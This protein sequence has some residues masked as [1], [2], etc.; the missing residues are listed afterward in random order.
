MV[1][2]GLEN[3]VVLVTGGSR[4]IGLE[5]ARDLLAQKAKVVICARKQEGLEKAEAEL[6]GG[7]NLLTVAANISK[8]DEVES[9]FSAV[10]EKFNGIDILVNNMGMNLMTASVVDADFSLWQKILDSN[11]NSTYLCAVNAARIMKDKGG[12]KIVNLS[13]IAG[14]RSAPGMGIYGVAKAAIEM[15]TKVLAHELASFNIQVNA[16]APSMVK[17]GFSMPFWSDENILNEIIKGIPAGR[18]AEI[19][20]VVNAILFLI[21]AKSDFITGQ[22]INVDGGASAV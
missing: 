7:E 6:Q 10:V 13:S 8:P 18:I 2:Y 4:G 9:L 22:V 17:T 16:V 19:E 5:T 14:S 21:S 11:L 3:K 1:N 15:L 12:G 20:D